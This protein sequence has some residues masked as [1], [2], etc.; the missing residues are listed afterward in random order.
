MLNIRLD[1]QYFAYLILFNQL[2]LPQVYHGDGLEPIDKA[3][4]IV[5]W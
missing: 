4:I 5:L 2:L 3:L 1:K